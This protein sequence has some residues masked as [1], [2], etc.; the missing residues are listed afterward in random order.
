[1]YMARDVAFRVPPPL[2]KREL[3]AALN[4][5]QQ[6]LRTPVVPATVATTV[7]AAPA[8]AAAAVS[9][10]AVPSPSPERFVTPPPRPM[11]PPSAPGSSAVRCVLSW[12]GF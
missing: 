2:Q 12:L 7:I 3:V 8:V 9:A 6:A 5:V 1:M 4:H 11:S 10:P